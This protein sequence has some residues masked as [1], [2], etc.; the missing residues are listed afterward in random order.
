MRWT[1]VTASVT[2]NKQG[3]SQAWYVCSCGEYGLLTIAEVTR[4]RSKSCGCLQHE[5]ARLTFIKHNMSRTAE[6]IAFRSAKARCTNPDHDSYKH[7][8]GRGIKFLFKSFEEFYKELG[9]RPVG[10][11]LDRRN[12][13]GNYEPGNIRWATKAT[14]TYNRRGS[15]GK[16][17][18]YE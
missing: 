2:K 10:M 1:F 7:Y 13:D 18:C 11:S 17:H 3:G 12:N 8:G 9:P 15:Y 14:Q 6:N 4:G 16:K 5:I